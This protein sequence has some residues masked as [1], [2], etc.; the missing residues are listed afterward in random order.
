MQYVIDHWKDILGWA[1]AGA[2]VVLIVWVL[3][4]RGSEGNQHQ[5][6][7]VPESGFT[8]CR[9]G[10]TPANS[11]TRGCRLSGSNKWFDSYRCRE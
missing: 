5:C 8:V 1:G 4:S 7:D 3:S 2:A 6:A 10:D 9:P 11:A